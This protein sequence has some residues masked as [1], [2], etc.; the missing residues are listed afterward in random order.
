MVCSRQSEFFPDTSLEKWYIYIWLRTN[1][2]LVS[3]DRSTVC[4]LMAEIFW[5][6]FLTVS[7][8]ISKQRPLRTAAY[9]FFGSPI[10]N[11]VK[12]NFTQISTIGLG[13]LN[14]GLLLPS[15]EV[16]RGNLTRRYFSSTFMSIIWLTCSSFSWRTPT[17]SCS[18]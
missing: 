13:H 8:F 10:F 2:S 15:P 7:S 16:S 5:I 17:N 1:L 9:L 18:P 4:F 3:S 12:G 14:E 6:F 11:L